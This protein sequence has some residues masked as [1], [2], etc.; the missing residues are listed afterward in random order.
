MWQSLWA[1]A[2]S[3]LFGDGLGADVAG[4]ASVYLA[5]E[6]RRSLDKE[7]ER[8]TTVRLRPGESYTVI[9]RPPA[10]REE[11]RLAAAK[12]RLQAR[13]DHLSRPTRRQVRTARKL[14]AAQR[15]LDRRSPGGRRYAKALRAESERARAFDKVMAPSRRQAQVHAELESV[16]RR[17]DDSRDASLHRARAGVKRR[18]RRERARVYD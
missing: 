2:L 15:R 16:T 13:D 5:D 12:A 4:R 3:R 14:R 7:P 18:P 10:T 11:R 6:V 17:L 9:A 8:L 1:T